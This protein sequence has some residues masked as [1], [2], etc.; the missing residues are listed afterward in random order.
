MAVRAQVYHSIGHAAGTFT[1]PQARDAVLD[2]ACGLWV[3]QQ[4]AGHEVAVLWRSQRDV[5]PLSAAFVGGNHIELA[6]PQHRELRSWPSWEVLETVRAEPARLADGE[7]A[8]QIAQVLGG[9]VDSIAVGPAGQPAALWTQERFPPWYRVV[10]WS[11]SL[12]A[13]TSPRV[14]IWGAPLWSA[15]GE[16]AVAAFDGIRRGIVTIDPGDGRTRW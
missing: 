4:K 16:L 13:M 14:R 5:M 7:L 12:Q 8:G 9:D 15:S 2:R 10:I 6:Y 11:G 3:V 1:A